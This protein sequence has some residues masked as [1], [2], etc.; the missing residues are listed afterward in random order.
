[1]GETALL[2][3]REMKG[4][5]LR[6]NQKIRALLILQM[7]R[8]NDQ[9]VRLNRRKSLIER[10]TNLLSALIVFKAFRPPLNLSLL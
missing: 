2:L 1:M 5:I 10:N 8:K 3:F 7:K 6:E 4:Q 9:T